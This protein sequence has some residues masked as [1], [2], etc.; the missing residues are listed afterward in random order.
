M[1]K[2]REGG[3]LSG[4]ITLRKGTHFAHFLNNNKTP[5]KNI[6]QGRG[7]ERRWL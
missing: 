5:G 4:R 1:G 7:S 6:K 3:K 2:A